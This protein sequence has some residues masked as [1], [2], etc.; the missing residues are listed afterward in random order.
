MVE[1]TG[2]RSGL[3]ASDRPRRVRIAITPFRQGSSPARAVVNAELAFYPQFHRVRVQPKSAPM[4]RPRHI[5][6]DHRRVRASRGPRKE[7]RS[8]APLQPRCAQ[9]PHAIPPAGFVRW[10]RRRGGSARL[11]CGNTHRSRHPTEVPPLPRRAPGGGG[12]PSETPQRLG[13]W[14][15]DRGPCA[16]DSW[17]RKGYGLIWH[18]FPCKVRLAPMG[19]R[20]CPQS[21]R[22]W[23][24]DWAGRHPAGPAPAIVPR[25]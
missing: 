8:G 14:P 19:G 12:D 16:I 13:G 2:G 1:A 23:S 5:H 7:S 25:R 24:W 22:P 3:Q 9:E 15:R 20:R 17:C 18:R 10:P 4:G 6:G 11:G 21:P